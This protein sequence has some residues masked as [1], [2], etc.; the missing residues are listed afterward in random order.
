MV[1]PKNA[2]R[3]KARTLPLFAKAKIGFSPRSAKTRPV[4]PRTGKA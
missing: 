3:G 1:R 4:V 2:K